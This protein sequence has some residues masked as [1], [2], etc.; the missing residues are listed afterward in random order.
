MAAG[1]IA[2]ARSSPLGVLWRFSRP[3]TIIGTT[4]SVGGLYAI[5]ASELPGP[6]PSLFDLWWTFVAAACVNVFIVGLNQLEDIEIDR[7]NKPFLPLAAGELT[8]RA[9]R[10]IVAVAGVVPVLLALTQGVT[11]LAGVVAALLVGIA[12]SSPPLRLKRFPVLAAVSISGVRSVVV[13]VVVFLHFSGG[14]MVGPVWA[15][16]A[17]VL[18]FSFAIAVLKDVPDAE[19]DRRFQ[20]A[21]FTV[22]LGPERAVAMGMGALTVAYLAMALVGP[23]V[24]D[25]VEPVVLSATH[26]AALAVLWRWRA[27]VELRDRDGYTRFYMRVWKL[28]FLEYVILPL[29]CAV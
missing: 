26:L 16:T 3:H 11:E 20:I 21:T 25:G 4:L 8:P 6:A 17:F 19:G 7:I 5:A 14:A 23:F 9:G 2:L 1:A 29:A 13:N 24:L 22:R 18:P 10:A 15:L 28:F 27:D 12:Y